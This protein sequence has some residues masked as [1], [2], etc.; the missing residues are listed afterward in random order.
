[1]LQYNWKSDVTQRI[2]NLIVHR[3]DTL[4][5]LIVEV[6]FEVKFRQYLVKIHRQR[7]SK[8]LETH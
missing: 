6:P 5:L 3:N 4:T 2:K 7:I 8:E 1:M